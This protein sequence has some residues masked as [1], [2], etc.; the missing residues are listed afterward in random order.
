VSG[1][2]PHQY[3]IILLTI[4]IMPHCWLTVTIVLVVV[5]VWLYRHSCRASAPAAPAAQQHRQR[6][7]PP[8]RLAA[9]NI[10]TQGLQSTTTLYLPYLNSSATLSAFSLLPSYRLAPLMDWLGVRVRVVETGVGVRVDL[11]QHLFKRQ[12]DSP[13]RG[14]PT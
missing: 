11:S 13:H 9:H 3:R 6:C 1:L 8:A 5:E 10:E 7:N 14:L 2:S 4:L 12:N